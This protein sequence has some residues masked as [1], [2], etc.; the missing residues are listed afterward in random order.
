QD[1]AKEP[2]AVWCFCSGKL[3]KTFEG[4]NGPL[5]DFASDEA[6]GWY[7]K[8]LKELCEQ[9][10][11]IPLTFTYAS[12]ERIVAQQGSFTMCFKIH[13][14]HDC[15]IKQIGPKY[16]RRLLIPH[17]K[18]PEFLLRLR[19]MNITGSVLFPGVDGLGQSVRELVSLGVHYK[20]LS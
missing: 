10:V 18:K 13:Q 2:G 11:V 3:R 7:E 15:I 5:P 6:P 16:I 4:E 8:K 9:R 20:A 14:N 17:D 19:E 1:G 12:S